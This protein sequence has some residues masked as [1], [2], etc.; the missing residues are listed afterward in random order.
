MDEGNPWLH[1]WDNRINRERAERSN[2]SCRRQ[3]D[4]RLSIP[5]L[6]P[7][8]TERICSGKYGHWTDM[9]RN[10]ALPA[11]W[12]GRFFHFRGYKIDYR[13]VFEVIFSQFLS[14][15]SPSKANGY[16]PEYVA[17]H[18]PKPWHQPEALSQLSHRLDAILRQGIR[19]R[20]GT[21][22]GAPMEGISSGGVM[23]T[24]VRQLAKGRL[25]HKAASA[26][27]QSD[28]SRRCFMLYLQ[29]VL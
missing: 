13:M 25:Q 23:T 18:L 24:S 16:A 15:E 3:A 6:E 10:S 14:M 1:D 19:E 22:V 21:A 29:G 27:T 11:A 4:P 20:P 26:T 7:L 28:C 8:E 5:K 17:T 2:S 12:K 9:F